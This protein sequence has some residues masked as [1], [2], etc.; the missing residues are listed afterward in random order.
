MRYPVDYD[1][2]IQEANENGMKTTDD[3]KELVRAIVGSVNDAYYQGRLD[4]LKCGGDSN[5]RITDF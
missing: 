4:Q 5:E 3:V 1:S 2:L